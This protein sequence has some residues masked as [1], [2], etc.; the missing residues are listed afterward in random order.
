MHRYIW[1]SRMQLNGH[2]LHLVDLKGC[3]LVQ[4]LYCLQYSIL[5]LSPVLLPGAHHL[6][7]KHLVLILKWHW[8]YFSLKMILLKRSKKK[9]LSWLQRKLQ[10]SIP[11][12][13]ELE[14]NQ[15]FAQ[16]NHGKSLIRTNLWMFWNKRIISVTR[17]FKAA[18]NQMQCLNKTHPSSKYTQQQMHMTAD[19]ALLVLVYVIKTLRIHFPRFYS[20]HIKILSSVNLGFGNLLYII[21][22]LRNIN[23]W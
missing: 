10:L 9:N 15:F 21:A 5:S 7:E 3:H 18:W 17:D 8:K 19:P 14:L 20:I 6:L 13:A 22:W 2:F 11:L 23:T 12:T 4:L 16:I 1:A